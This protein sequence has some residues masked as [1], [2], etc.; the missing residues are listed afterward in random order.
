MDI[1]TE[2]I[3]EFKVI[4]FQNPWSEKLY[5]GGKVELMKII[6]D[7]DPALNFKILEKAQELFSWLQIEKEVHLNDDNIWEFIH[8]IGMKPE[9]EYLLLK[10]PSQKKRQTF[11]LEHLN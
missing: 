3:R 10:L 4:D 8:K 2:G 7:E 5:A 11:I 9:E 6:A 1:K